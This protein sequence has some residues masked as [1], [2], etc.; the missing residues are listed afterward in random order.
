MSTENIGKNTAI[1]VPNALLAAG[2]YFLAI[3]FTNNSNT[4]SYKN[5]CLLSSVVL[6]SAFLILNKQVSLNSEKEEEKN[7]Q[8]L[9]YFNWVIDVPILLY[10]YCI[11]LKSSSINTFFIC[12]F[13]ILMVL[14]GYFGIQE[15]TTYTLIL[16]ALSIISFLLI[17]GLL[18]REIRKNFKLENP[19]KYS[20][21]LFIFWFLNWA[22]YLVP[23]FIE[24]Q[25]L[26]ECKYNG[27]IEI[28]YGIADLSSKIFFPYALLWAM[29][30]TEQTK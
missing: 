19:L 28:L 7:D 10:I 6:I 30:K 16:I 12:I 2:V 20:F 24:F 26:E 5:V 11:A 22:L 23:Y 21:Y 9:R 25:T 1:L 29:K 4:Q 27:V 15:E 14:T 13:G 17:T 18:L 3:S 8:T